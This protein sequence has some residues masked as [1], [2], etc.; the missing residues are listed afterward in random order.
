MKLSLYNSII[1][2]IKI[3]KKEKKE[4]RGDQKIQWSFGL[5]TYKKKV[6]FLDANDELFDEEIKKAILCTVPDKGEKSTQRR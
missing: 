3:L 4:L 6:A 1:L 5:S 2:C